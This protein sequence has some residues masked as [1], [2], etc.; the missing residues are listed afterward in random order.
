MTD[1]SYWNFPQCK[2]NYIVKLSPLAGV[3][4]SGTTLVSVESGKTTENLVARVYDQSGLMV[5]NAKVKLDLT[6]QANSGGHLHNV[7]RPKGTLSSGT[8]TGETITGNTST[9]GFVFTFKAPAPAGDH[10]IT[11]I[12]TDGKNC[13]QEGADTVWVGVKDLYQ[14]PPVDLLYHLI[15][16]NRDQY[17]PNNHYLTSPAITILR[18]LAGDYRQMFPSA[19]V[20]YLNDASLERGGYFDIE[21]KWN[22]GDHKEHRRGTVIDIR[23]NREVGAIPEANFEHFEDIALKLGAKAAQ[24][25]KKD[26]QG[27]CV[28]STRHYH[29]RLFGRQE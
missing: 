27:Q 10:K 14:I 5:P 24:H 3:A 8:M 2:Q 11:A 15:E 17:H 21:R 16:P 7:N 22:T 19:P 4:E 9:N 12:C 28:D 13:K 1:G 25:C 23:A 20:L 29:V 26:A 6:A 18:A